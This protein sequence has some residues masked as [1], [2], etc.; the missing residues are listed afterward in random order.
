MFRLTAVVLAAILVGLLPALAEAGGPDDP[1]REARWDRADL[2]GE[3]RVRFDFLSE[4]V[5]HERPWWLSSRFRVGT[6]LR[7][8]DGLEI[9]LELE[10]FNGQFAG[11]NTTLGTVGLDRPFRVSRTDLKQL[12]WVLPRKAS[13]A[14]VRPTGRF[15][16]GLQTFEWGSGMLSN[17]GVGDPIFGDAMQGAVVARVGGNLAPWAARESAGAA[18]GLVFVVAGDLVFRDD[19]AHL[20]HGDLAFQGLGAVLWK[21]TRSSLGL[22]ATARYQRDREDPYHP[23]DK[24]PWVFAVPVD[25]YGKVRLTPDESPAAFGLEG[26]VALISGSSTRAYGEESSN[27]SD[28][29]S[30]G[31]LLRARFDH[32]V[33]RLS[34]LMELGYASGDADIRDGVARTFHMNSD[35]EVGLLLFEH[36]LPLVQARSIDRAADPELSGTPSPGLRHG[37]PQGS[38]HNAVYLY[39]TFRW[40]PVAT[41]DVRLGGLVAWSASDVVD[42]YES[43]IAGGYNQGFDGEQAESRLYGGEVLAGFRGTIP[44]P[45]GLGLELG[46]EGAV[47]VP[48]AVF[49]GLS[50]DGSRLSILGTVRARA[51]FRW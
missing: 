49:D 18:R 46:V 5:G 19:N 1:P 11:P 25:L 38:V 30:F 43:A 29:A 47:F 12:Q 22:F 27:G 51:D 40:R 48:G 4:F 8:T 50:D 36:V 42:V 2:Y 33:A 35:H 24:R 37:I 20:F 10:A 15:T 34:V 17:D 26:E 14:L 39:P 45:A 7:P 28:I 41:L 23:A 31:A 6:L 3:A 13:L 21:T 44:L 16:V 9:A 32:D